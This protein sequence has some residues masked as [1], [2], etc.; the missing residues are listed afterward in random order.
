MRDA[1]V[2]L[3]REMHNLLDVRVCGRKKRE[4]GRCE[5][6]V[7]SVLSEENVGRTQCYLDDSVVESTTLV[8]VCGKHSLLFWC[9]LATALCAR[10]SSTFVALTA[11]EWRE[12]VHNLV[13]FVKLAFKVLGDFVDAF[14][15]NVVS[16]T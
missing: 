1:V 2:G 13:R 6:C 3:L 16:N 11:L 5:A 14:L 9:T 15:K 4:L 10:V 8:V 12:R 7:L